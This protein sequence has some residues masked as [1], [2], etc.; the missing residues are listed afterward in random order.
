MRVKGQTR[1]RKLKRIA[2][3]AGKIIACA[4]CGAVL[5]L[6]VLGIN[7]LNDKPDLDLWHTVKLKEE[8]TASSPEDSFDEYLKLEERLFAELEREVYDRTG[9]AE[10]VSINR[11]ER[12]S[13]SDPARWSRN[14]NRSYELAPD[15]ASGKPEAAVLLIH[16]LSDSPYSL[17]HLGERLRA[18]G[19]YVLGLRV[20]G[21][22]TVPAALTRTRWQD[23]AAAVELAMRH[24]QERAG[25]R[26]L[27]VVGYSN[28]G[29]LAV[30][31]ALSALEHSEL[32]APD[33]IVLISPEIGVSRMASGFIWQERVGRLLG[34]KKLAWTSVNPEYD[35]F[36]YNSFPANAG[37]LAHELTTVN[38]G[39]VAA[40]ADAGTLDGLP[41]V[42]AF[43]S[44]VDATVSVTALVS[45]L[46]ARLPANHHE[47]VVFD[48]NRNPVVGALL[49]RD[50]KDEIGLVLGDPTRAFEFT[51]L[52]NASAMDERVVVRS[53]APGQ[54][55]YV[56]AD[57]GLRWPPRI[58]SLSHVALPFPGD[59]P[60]YGSVGKAEG[61]GFQIGSAALRGEKGVLRIPAQEVLRQRWNPFYP[62]L[63]RRVLERLGLVETVESAGAAGASEG[64][65][66]RRPEDRGQ[67]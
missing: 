4:G 36:K 12:G 1:W 58:Y 62:Y 40:L 57:T 59:D 44:A 13:R 56:Q 64:G 46:F 11:Y 6:L 25:G 41:P 48:I 8:F 7:S 16:G 30:Q 26:P 51:V 49:G 39:K 5:A 32:P 20:P 43:Q 22:G 60:L 67:P 54:A 52:T 63:E 29:A 9:A 14:W 19:A 45:D 61:A 53:W 2:I 50:P 18:G 66:D 38:R 10:G 55:A 3:R 28:G 17:R 42:I 21:H 31:Y 23:M 35:P 37:N 34:L 15:T 24:L 47:L 65:R 33:G 27:Y